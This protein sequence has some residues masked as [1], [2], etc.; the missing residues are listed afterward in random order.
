MKPPFRAASAAILVLVMLTACG[1]EGPIEPAGPEQTAL[2]LFELARSEEPSDELI[3]ALFGAGLDERERAA[4]FEALDALST[5]STV[6][7]VGSEALEGLNRVAVDLLAGLP[8]GGTARYSVQLEPSA[9]GE[10]RILWFQGPGVE[11]PRR[12]RPRGTGLTTSALPHADGA[13]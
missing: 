5:A 12:K 4:L 3:A 11:W 13:P 7:A 8:A 6:E 9:Q 10:W 2:Q 1:E